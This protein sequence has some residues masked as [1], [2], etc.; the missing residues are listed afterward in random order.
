MNAQVEMLHHILSAI[1]VAKKSGDPKMMAAARKLEL[2]MPK[3]KTVG[4]VL[5]LVESTKLIVEN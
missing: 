5:R 3:C 2:G 1:A 4:D